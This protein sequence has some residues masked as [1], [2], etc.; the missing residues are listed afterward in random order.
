[1]YKPVMFSRE[2][3]EYFINAESQPITFKIPPVS[4]IITLYLWIYNLQKY[5]TTIL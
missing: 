1:M 3:A 5:I 2:S 4:F